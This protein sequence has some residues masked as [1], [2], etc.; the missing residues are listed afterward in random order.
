M[1]LSLQDFMLYHNTAFRVTEATGY[2]L[3]LIDLTDHSNAMLEQFSLIFTCSVLPGLPQ[4]TYIL[5]RSDGIEFALF[6]TP[7]GPAGGTM[8]Y[9]S[10]FSRFVNGSSTAQSLE[11]TIQR[12]ME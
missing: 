4:G 12:T 8:R 1:T 3:K 11:T 7:L 2:E 5:I 9:E 10:V 6:M